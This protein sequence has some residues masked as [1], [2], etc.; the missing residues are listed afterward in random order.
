MDLQ[1][2]GKRMAVTGG[3]SGIGAAI[4]KTLAAEGAEVFCCARDAARLDAFLSGLPREWRV[5]GR[6]LDVLDDQA[7]AEW[8]ADIGAFDGLAANVS[9]LKGSWRESIRTDMEA[10]IALV[11]AA[12]PYLRQSSAGALCYIGSMSASQPAA[13]FE[14]YGAAKAA[15]AHYMKSLSCQLLPQVRVNTVSPGVTEFPGGMW[16]QLRR[17][18]PEAYR[19]K[20]AEYPLGRFAAPEEVARVAAFLLS[21]A[22]SFVS[23]ANWYVDGGASP[24][25]QF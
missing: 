17:E 12:T 5:S 23:G 4:V 9:A 8:L 6:A 13:L 25:V 14:G 24:L 18:D 21:P 22:A 2:R 15:M 11:E 19:R 20:L 1:L 7:V 16:D 10:T 3:S